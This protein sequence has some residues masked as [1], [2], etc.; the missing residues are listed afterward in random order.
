M[1]VWARL[2]AFNLLKMKSLSKTRKLIRF[3]E[4]DTY[5]GGPS[6]LITSKCMILK[7]RSI[8]YNNSLRYS[9]L[10]S[11]HTFLSVSTV[12]HGDQSF[13]EFVNILQSRN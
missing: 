6:S 1:D 12:F 9:R 2:I 3:D 13:F 11:C 8:Q 7:N 4:G 10:P 5:E